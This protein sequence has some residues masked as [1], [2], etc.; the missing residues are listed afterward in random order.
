MARDPLPFQQGLS[1]PASLAQYGTEEPKHVPRSLAEFE[2]RF[3]RRFD[4]P[5]L[6][7]R[8]ARATTQMGSHAIQAAK[9]G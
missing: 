4:L 3:N 9:T 7:E 5:S 1:L 6:V 8:P 2:Y